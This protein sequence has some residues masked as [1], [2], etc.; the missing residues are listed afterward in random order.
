MKFVTHSMC[1]LLIGFILCTQTMIENYPNV[2]L[3]KQ[4]FYCQTTIDWTDW[5]HAN[6]NVPQGGIPLCNQRF[7]LLLLIEKNCTT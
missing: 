7:D 5:K 1:C 6:I 4:F 2:S 3:C